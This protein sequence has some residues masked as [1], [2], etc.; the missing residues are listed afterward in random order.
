MSQL[1]IMLP[2]PPRAPEQWF[3]IA[4]ALQRWTIRLGWLLWVLMI[5]SAGTGYATEDRGRGPGNATPGNVQAR[6]SARPPRLISIPNASS[7]TS[8]AGRPN[9]KVICRSLGLSKEI[10]SLLEDFSAIDDGR[11]RIKPHDALA[12]HFLNSAVERVPFL[13]FVRDY[14][15]K[16]VKFHIDLDV[17]GVAIEIKVPLPALVW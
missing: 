9:Y 15:P 8:E 12:G 4:A 2:S 1:R 11:V 7:P 13:P 6:A 3:T 10:A 14:I 16:G 5:S 17:D